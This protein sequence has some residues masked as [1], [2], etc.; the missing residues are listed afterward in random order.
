[1]GIGEDTD[2]HGAWKSLRPFT[3]PTGS[4]FSSKREIQLSF[5]DR[6]L[7]RSLGS[8]GNYFGGQIETISVN[9]THH[10][11]LA[12]RKTA[13]EGEL[14]RSP[15]RNLGPWSGLQMTLCLIY[16]SAWLFGGVSGFGK[17]LRA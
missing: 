13:T 5:Q 3:F 15:A 12:Y 7:S 1:M 17:P 4:T 6:I 2:S 14:L 9:R 16:N 8:S 11:I 10:G